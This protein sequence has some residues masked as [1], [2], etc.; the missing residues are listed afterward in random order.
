MKTTLLSLLLMAAVLSCVGAQ[1]PLTSGTYVIKNK[2]FDTQALT[3]MPSGDIAGSKYYSNPAATV[4]DSQKWIIAKTL[5]DRDGNTWQT[6]QNVGTKT[7]LTV[8]NDDYK[9]HLSQE[10]FH[11]VIYPHDQ[12]AGLYHIHYVPSRWADLELSDSQDGA[13]LGLGDFR[14]TPP[15][16]ALV[17]EF[18]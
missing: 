4:P 5:P 7:F 16:M 6:I 12:Q 2:N 10:P 3:V 9:I 8:N 11:W 17:W 1:D 15:N 13:P 14:Q 18:Q